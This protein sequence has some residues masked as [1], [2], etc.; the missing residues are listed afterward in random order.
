M[1]LVYQPD[2]SALSP[3]V[4][5]SATQLL[6]NT[7]GSYRAPYPKVAS[8]I[9]SKGYTAVDY[10]AYLGIS[11]SGGRR[12]FLSSGIN[13][14]TPNRLSEIYAVDAGGTAWTT[15]GSFTI[16]SASTVAD[17]DPWHFCQYENQTIAACKTFPIK[18]ATTGVFATLSNAPHARVVDT[19]NDAL[20]AW[21]VNDGSTNY[22][23]EL[24]ISDVGDATDWTPADGSLSFRTQLTDC[25]GPGTAMIRYRDFMVIFKSRGMW[26]AQYTGDDRIYDVRLFSS[27][28]GCIG[29]DACIVAEDILYFCDDQNVY[30]FDGASIQSISDPSF[31]TRTIVQ[32]VLN[33][34]TGGSARLTQLHFDDINKVLTVYAR[35]VARPQP[36]YCFNTVSGKWGKIDAG[37]T[38]ADSLLAVLN[39]PADDLIA[40]T[41]LGITASSNENRINF[42]GTVVPSGTFRNGHNSDSAGS[43]VTAY[44]G[45]AFQMQALRRVFF[46]A[47]S[48]TGVTVSDSTKRAPRS[49]ATTQ[50]ASS[51]GSVSSDLRAE[52]RCDGN[53]HK[54]TFAWNAQT[55][56]SP[57]DFR[58]WQG[59][60]L[61][62]VRS[63]TR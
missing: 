56:A 59:F 24:W 50:G 17:T 26:L 7:D 8:G 55:N 10:T 28:V 62:M 44:F 5:V 32:S 35:D 41:N 23:D 33:P 21:N 52:I 40:F 53:F 31:I 18:T 45:D 58:K 60:E 27:N 4:L 42:G 49:S 11:S 16:A 13:I 38:F 63:G 34:D 43:A 3:D 37:S 54:L 61:D 20:W 15:V 25:P 29:K 48:N 19:L 22:P 47:D 39:G 12:L 36:G 9:D 30:A 2:N 6:P 1:S 57:A 14:S 46:N 51:T